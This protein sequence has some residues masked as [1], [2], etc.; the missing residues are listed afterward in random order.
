MSEAPLGI[1]CFPFEKEGA[2][3]SKSTLSSWQLGALHTD[4]LTLLP[5]LV[6]AG[7]TISDLNF[8]T[9]R[10]MEIIMFNPLS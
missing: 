3:G 4:T 8:G 5:P 1:N 10:D 2:L 9:R 7:K 6:L